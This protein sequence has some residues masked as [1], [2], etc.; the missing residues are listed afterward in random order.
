ML[1]LGSV[2]SDDPLI[3]GAV[4]VVGAVV[5]V[6]VVAVKAAAATHCAQGSN[7]L[8]TTAL[9]F[10]AGPNFICNIPVRCS[11]VSSGNPDPSIL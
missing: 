5:A 8:A 11:S 6:A 10:R 2:L 4:V 1:L 7:R 3:L 9:S